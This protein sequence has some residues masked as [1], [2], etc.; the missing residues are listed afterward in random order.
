[1]D[2]IS[3]RLALLALDNG[4]RTLTEAADLR[5]GYGLCGALI[6]DLMVAGALHA[7][8]DGL[9]T[10]QPQ[11]ALDKPY[12]QEAF[13]AVPSYTSLEQGA[14]IKAVYAVLPRVKELVLDA[15]VA[16]GYAREDTTRLKWSFAL[17]SYALKPRYAGYRAN[18][19]QALRQDAVPLHDGWALQVAD[20]CGLLGGEDEAGKKEWHAALSCLETLE[21]P[22]AQWRR[23]TAHLA[24]LLPATIA[25]SHRLPRMGKKAAYAATWEW[26]GFWLKKEKPTLIQAS[27]EYTASLEQNGFSETTDSYVVV[28]GMAENIKC[29]RSAL[30]VKIPLE[31]LDGHTA[32]SAKQVYGFPLPPEE[33]AEIF[34][35]LGDAAKPVKNAQALCRLL[36]K[37]GI[38]AELVEVKKKRFQVKLKSCVQVEFC[39]LQAGGR[40]YL[41]ACV[42]GPDYAVTQAHSHNF[43][44]GEVME[45]G[46]VEFLKRCQM[47]NVP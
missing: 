27:E 13:A 3:E 39:T 47:E 30:E 31:T 19:L 46:Y 15:L 26:R 29:R 11:A 20:A 44:M 7:E 40:K 41:T 2:S 34:P 42:E 22:P 4:H 18:I 10:P 6:L 38:R 8:E 24:T 45:M 21:G 25:H 36:N 43:R 35:R 28:E 32:F 9:I 14:M 17:K 5:L 1:M 16:G 37:R 33:V 23:L 12:L